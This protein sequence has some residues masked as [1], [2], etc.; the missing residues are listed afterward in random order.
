MFKAGKSGLIVMVWS[1]YKIPPKIKL[2][3][4][5]AN[6]LIPNGKVKIVM[7]ICIAQMPTIRLLKWQNVNEIQIK[8]SALSSVALSLARTVFSSWWLEIEGNVDVDVTS[9]IRRW[10]S[11]VGPEVREGEA[12]G[13]REWVTNRFLGRDC[14]RSLGKGQSQILQR[15]VINQ[16]NDFFFGNISLVFKAHNAL[17]P[18]HLLY[19]STEWKGW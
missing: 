6:L 17:W 18:E 8:R 12:L 3:G 13:G 14:S 16:H 5:I 15:C 19:W 11:T 7:C 9:Y 2:M 1:M 10:R 4:E